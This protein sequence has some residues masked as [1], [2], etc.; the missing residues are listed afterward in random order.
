MLESVFFFFLTVY[1]QVS[2]FLLIGVFL[3]ARLYLYSPVSFCSDS[4]YVAI[5]ANAYLKLPL[6]TMD[7]FTYFGS[8]YF[9][10]YLCLSYSVG[11]LHPYVS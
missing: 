7:M 4:S 3:N 8:F 10:V 2:F 9:D 5:P 1:R 6:F 11:G